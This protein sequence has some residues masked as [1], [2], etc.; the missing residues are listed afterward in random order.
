MLTHRLFTASLEEREAS[1]PSQSVD[2]SSK[3]Q[4]RSRQ[5][6]K[7]LWLVENCLFLPGSFTPRCPGDRQLLLQWM[8]RI[9]YVDAQTPLT[10]HDQHCNQHL[11]SQTHLRASTRSRLP[12]PGLREMTS[13]T[14]NSRSGILPPGSI[15]NKATSVSRMDELFIP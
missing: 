11:G 3:E 2:T 9:W 4:S 14:T 12:Q 8:T 6:E 10:S 7:K 1:P 13:A 5:V 15:A